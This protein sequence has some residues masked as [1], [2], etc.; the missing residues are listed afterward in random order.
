MD[1]DIRRYVAA[2]SVRICMTGLKKRYAPAYVKA[3]QII[4]EEMPVVVLFYGIS[5]LLIKPWV[6]RF[7]TA[8]IKN[9][10][11]KDIILEPH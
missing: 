8:Y 9:T 1:K 11:W 7:R 10:F 3:R 2:G 4:M 5:Q 6:K